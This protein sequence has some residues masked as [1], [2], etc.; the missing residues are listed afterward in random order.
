MPCW[1]VRTT[2]LNVEVANR[3]LLAKALSKIEGFSA[4]VQMSDRIGF[5]FHGAAGTWKNGVITYRGG[6]REMDANVIQREYSRESIKA[7]A[8]KQG[9]QLRFQKNG[10]IQA[11]RR[12]FA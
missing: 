8:K 2:S 3:D 11:V 12:R 5:R 9:W 1:Q 7:T 6:S 10:Q 4:V